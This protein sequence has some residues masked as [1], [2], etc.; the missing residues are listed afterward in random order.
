H[1]GAVGEFENKLLRRR[2]RSVCQN[3]SFRPHAPTDQPS[4]GRVAIAK[5]TST[6]IAAETGTRVLRPNA[7]DGLPKT[8]ARRRNDRTRRRHPP[9][10]RC[11][12]QPIHRTSYDATRHADT[13]RAK[14]ASSRQRAG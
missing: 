10:V 11:S 14:L 8:N 12:S 6:P 1:R 5:L 7:P 3:L 4:R 9:S 2:R 13:R